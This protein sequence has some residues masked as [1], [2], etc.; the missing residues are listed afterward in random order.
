V[1]S[2]WVLAVALAMALGTASAAAPVGTPEVTVYA[3]HAGDTLASLARVGL[4]GRDAVAAVMRI[5]HIPVPRRLRAG[6]SLRIPRALLRDEGSFASVEAFSGPVTLMVG[7]HALPVHTGVQVGEG[8]QI[9]TGRNGFVTLRLRDDSAVSLPSQT[10]V[11]IAR[12]RRVLLNGAVEREF[13]LADGHLHT[14]VT[15]MIQPESTFR[16]VTPLTVSAVRGTGFRVD[17]AAAAQTGVTE[18][19]EGRVAVDVPVGKAPVLVPAGLGLAA[20]AQGLGTPTPLL[21]APGLVDPGRVQTGAQLA[22]R[23]VP[24]DGAVAYHAQISRDAGALDVVAETTV[25]GPDIGF[26]ALATGSWFLRLTAIDAQGIEGSA[27]SFVFDRFRNEVGGSMAQSRAGGHRSYQFKW[28]GVAD[29]APRYRFRLW[30]DG[31][32]TPAV[33]DETG[34]QSHVLDIR[35]LPPGDYRWQVTSTLIAGGRVIESPSPVQSFLIAGSR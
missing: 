25:P 33:V 32:D 3:V 26:D 9:Q 28:S 15:H 34:L 17:Y 18:V 8:A 21:P 5:N 14:T 6:E 23:V 22:F 20:S 12:L 30:R 7:G 2:S 35:D 16:V 4:V 13:R 11:V 29:G 1:R 24:K 31:H 10:S 19:D 27:T